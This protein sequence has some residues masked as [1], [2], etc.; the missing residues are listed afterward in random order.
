MPSV[1]LKLNEYDY[2]V[3][4]YVTIDENIFFISELNNCIIT[5]SLNKCFSTT[6]LVAE[7]LN[8][9]DNLLYSVLEYGN[10]LNCDI[11]QGSVF[12]RCGGIFNADFIANSLGSLSVKEL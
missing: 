11:S 10:F 7:F 8:F 3:L 9:D 1:N 4:C 2:V 5:S 12:V 6:I